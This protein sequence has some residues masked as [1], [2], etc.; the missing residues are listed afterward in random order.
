[1]IEKPGP[2]RIAVVGYGYWG[3]KHARVLNGMQCVDVV[4][5]DSDRARLASAVAD[6]PGVAVAESLEKVLPRV[7]GVVVATPPTA[8]HPVAL[9]ALRAGR[10]V[11]VEKP[12]AVS[13]VEACEMVGAAERAGVHLMVGH[14]FEFNAGVWKLKHLINAGDLGKVLYIDSARLNLGLYRS[15]VD[16]IWDLAPHDISIVSYLLGELPSTVSVW[17]HGNFARQQ[18]DVAFLRLDFART[19]VQ[20]FIHV[21]WLDPCRVRR[22]TVVGDRKMAS[23]NDLAG[24]DRVKIFD[25]GVEMAAAAEEDAD[26]HPVTYRTGTV[27]LEP[28]E[29]REPLLVQDSHFVECIRT[30]QAPRCDGRRGL[31][32]VRVLAAADAARVSNRAQ[33][34]PSASVE[35]DTACA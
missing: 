20:A 6:I 15:D 3:A 11:L 1:M 34:V 30:G 29:M 18:D 4:V 27:A 35:I 8:H 17:S 2:T 10:H 12:M 13:V 31:D 28:V 23:L 5:V 25:A 16:V 33:H 32:I 14:T 21:S 7:D 22:V 26:Y 24:D 19:G 9:R